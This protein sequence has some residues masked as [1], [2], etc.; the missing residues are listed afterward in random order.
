MK[1]WVDADACPKVIR[2]TIVRAAERTGVECTFVA[3]HVVPVPKRTNIHSLQV[4]A[5]FDIADNE[6]VRRV[7]AND[8]VITSDIPL[9]DEVISKGAQ[10]LSSR[11]ELY[12][13]DTIKARLNIRDFM[14][15]MRSSGIQTGGP[16]ALS[17]TEHREFA[18]HLDRIL[19]KR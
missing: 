8:L 7:E 2:E 11:G 1:L 15:T 13:K 6:I 17:Q 3:N 10:A 5:G 9:A 14:D 4:P 12:T 19:A 18:N 16:A